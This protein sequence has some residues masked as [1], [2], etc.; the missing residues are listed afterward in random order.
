M[1]HIIG[2]VKKDGRIKISV[3][4]HHYYNASIDPRAPM[5]GADMSPTIF[6]VDGSF[7]ESKITILDTPKYS[8]ASS[9][10]TSRAEKTQCYA[11][12]FPPAA[13][14]VDGESIV[15]LSTSVAGKNKR[16]H[17]LLSY[18]DYY[19]VF[20]TE[21]NT[22]YCEIVRYSLPFLVC[23]IYNITHVGPDNRCS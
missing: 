19:R 5:S 22:T 10:Q 3:S 6:L 23:R 7:S 18:M 17:V 8:T 21:T 11:A 12:D 2:L 20:E 9:C 16:A 1:C 13:I 14:L 15:R 4:S